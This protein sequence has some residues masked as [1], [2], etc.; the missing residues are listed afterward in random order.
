MILGTVRL[1]IL[2]GNKRYAHITTL[3]S[4]KVL[5]GLFGIEGLGS[6]D[7]VRRAFTHASNEELTLWLDRCMNTVFEPLLSEPWVLGL[8][9]TVKTLYGK[10]VEARI[11]YN[12]MNPGRPS[13]VY[14]AYCI[15]RLRMLLN[16]DVQAGNQVTS[17]RACGA[18]GL[19]GLAAAGAV[20]GDVAR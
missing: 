7:S 13:Q 1:P 17:E 9:A 20:A 18:V 16:V 10:Q 15:A 19:V 4:D 2:A 12:P 6:E 14:H 5:P 8:H 3:R 11:G